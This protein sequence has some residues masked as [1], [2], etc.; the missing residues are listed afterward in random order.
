MESSMSD[1]VAACLGLAELGGTVLEE[2]AGPGSS[3][4]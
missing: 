3:L 1:S 2:V 4:S